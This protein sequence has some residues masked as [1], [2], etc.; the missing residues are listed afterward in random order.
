[1]RWRFRG[2]DSFVYVAKLPRIFVS[3]P[4]PTV[5]EGNPLMAL[6]VDP[7]TGKRLPD[8]STEEL[9]QTTHAYMAPLAAFL[10]AR[11]A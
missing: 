8:M 11:L 10:T 3:K 6:Q 1:M 9:T 5:P 2:G 4:H 7:A